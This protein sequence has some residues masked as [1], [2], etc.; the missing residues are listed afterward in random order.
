M[1]K[2]LLNKEEVKLFKDGGESPIYTIRRAELALTRKENG[3]EVSE[4]IEHLILK[5]WIDENTLYS[6]AALIQKEFPENN[7]NWQETFFPVEKR[8][9]LN[10]VN[11]TKKLISD[12]NESKFNFNK[13]VERI[14][15]GIEEQNEFVND[16]VAR[17]VE[18]N[19]KKNGLLQ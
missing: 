13:L 19:L 12:D 1:I 16:Q 14:E 8:L 3:Y 18:I 5:S 7:I 4:W 6:L 11:K 2:I 17:I 15:T 10:H 9:Y